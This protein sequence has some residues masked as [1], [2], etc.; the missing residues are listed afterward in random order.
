MTPS[1]I[2][3]YNKPRKHHSMNFVVT[4]VTYAYILIETGKTEK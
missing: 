2:R 3:S 4:V 1:A